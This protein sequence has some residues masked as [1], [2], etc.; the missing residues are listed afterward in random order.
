MFQPGANL[1]TQG[2]ASR[3]ENVEVPHIDVRAPAA[4]DLLYPLGKRWVDRVNQNE[5]TLVAV[6]STAGINSA[7]WVLMGGSS[8]VVSVLGTAN[9]ITATTAAGVST[10]SL[11]AAITTPGSLTTT[12]TLAAGTSLSAG[13]TVT[14]GT[15]V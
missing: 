5:Y 1:Y 10:I 6:I 12:T 15:G 11:P 13:T 8:S 9:Q 2:F 3:P 4:T 7:V 14:A